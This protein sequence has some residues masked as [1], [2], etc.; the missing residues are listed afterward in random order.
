MVDSNDA[1][2]NI[3]DIHKILSQILLGTFT[4][5]LQLALTSP[6]VLDKR[7]EISHPTISSYQSLIR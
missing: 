2:I 3:E 7:C 1:L 4:N 6:K 5:F